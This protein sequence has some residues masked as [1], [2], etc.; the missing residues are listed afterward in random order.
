VTG[1][2]QCR[3]TR[4]FDNFIERIRLAV[5]R[6]KFLELRVK[7]ESFYAVVFDQ[8][9]GLDYPIPGND[10]AIRAIKLFA[11]L[12]ADS[13][14]EGRQVWEASM[15]DRQAEAEKRAAA[16]PHNVAERVRAREARRE[17]LRAQAKATV[18]PGRSRREEPGEA[19]A[20]A[21]EDGASD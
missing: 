1:V 10:D 16:G 6:E 9:A 19:V 4:F 15:R 18:H 7:L 2:K 21:A 20:A 14:A 12:V 3:Q 13:I 8:P 11:S 17:K 5:V